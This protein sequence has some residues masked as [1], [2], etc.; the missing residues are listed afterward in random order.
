[1]TEPIIV[2]RKLAPEKLVEIVQNNHEEMAKVDVDIERRILSIGGE[3]HSEGEELLVQDGSKS[4]DVW[5]TNLYPWKVP[6]ERVVYHLLINLKPVL[7]HREME[8]KDAALQKRIRGVINELLL[9]D[10]ENVPD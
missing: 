5:G 3:W 10:D 9:A 8:I 1:M 6:H 7:G 2:R 4:T